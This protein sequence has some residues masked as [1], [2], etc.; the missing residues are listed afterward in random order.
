M[1]RESPCRRQRA[2]GAVH[3]VPE[4]RGAHG[5]EL[6]GHTQGAGRFA[7]EIVAESKHLALGV[8]APSVHKRQLRERELAFEHRPGFLHLASQRQ[9]LFVVP[10][11]RGEIAR[12][13][14][15]LTQL[16]EGLRLAGLEP[17]LAGEPHGLFFCFPGQ[18]NLAL[19]EEHDAQLDSPHRAAAL[20]ADFGAGGERL[21]EGR[22][23]RRQVPHFTLDDGEVVEGADLP[24][25]VANRAD[26][27]Q[28][29][30]VILRGFT[31]LILLEQHH[32]DVAQ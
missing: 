7:F 28:R 10:A 18:A 14:G 11:R 27:R 13:R 5:E 9:R 6:D 24:T 17:R 4:E 30:L 25:L 16:V 21:L 8:G 29:L 15:D 2:A 22:A 31:E 32:A 3:V 26:N 12:C 23:R 20:V 1:L 19:R